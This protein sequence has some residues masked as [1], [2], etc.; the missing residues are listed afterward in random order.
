MKGPKDRP[1][2]SKCEIEYLHSLIGDYPTQLIIKRY[3]HWASMMNLPKRSSYAIEQKLRKLKIS[4]I[5]VGIYI[6]SGT[7]VKLLGVSYT[8]VDRWVQS[9]H[10]APHL[11]ESG[12]PRV[13]GIRPPRRLFLRS[14]MIQMALDHPRLLSGTPQENLFL[15]LEDA[16]LAADIAQRFPKRIGRDPVPVICVETGQ[17]YG[18]IAAA[19]RAVYVTKNCLAEAVKTGRRAN[20]YHWRRAVT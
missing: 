16:A 18:S 12:D 5:P 14:D 4:R 20:G 15:L 7:L 11:I 17:R 19:A 13:R 8:T 9:G 6:T 1:W 3:L 2:W 10:L